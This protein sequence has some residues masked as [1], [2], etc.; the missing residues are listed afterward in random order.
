[1]YDPIQPKADRDV[2]RLTIDVP[3]SLHNT[4]KQIANDTGE[5]IAATVRAM[6]RSGV[7]QR[8]VSR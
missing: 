1:L 8:Q 3:P 5:T 4:L 6:L 2:C 7:E